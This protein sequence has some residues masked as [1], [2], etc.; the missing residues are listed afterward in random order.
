MEHCV[1]EGDVILGSSE[2]V[3]GKCY[4]GS[5]GMTIVVYFD[6]DFDPEEC[7]ACNVEDLAEKGGDYE[8]CAYRVEIPCETVSVE[9][10]EPSS[11]PSIAPSKAPVSFGEV[12]CPKDLDI[13]YQEG[14]TDID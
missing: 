7:V 2:V 10:G 3:D 1:V 4:G 5:V 8:F 14:N 13:L 9:C 11:Q 12:D 6:S